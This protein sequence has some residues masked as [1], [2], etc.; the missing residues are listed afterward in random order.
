[1][2]DISLI[3][4]SSVFWLIVGYFLRAA[5]IHLAQDT[6][7]K[8]A[9]IKLCEANWSD[10]NWMWWVSVALIC[11]GFI[12]FEM[13]ILGGIILVI[14]ALAFS[15]LYLKRKEVEA[16]YVRGNRSDSTLH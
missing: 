4:P 5:L 13:P 15:M 7:G 9:Y 1:M 3:V 12:L 14:N 8:F 2:N 6:V 10:K 16:A 11:M